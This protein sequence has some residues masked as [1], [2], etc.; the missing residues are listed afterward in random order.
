MTTI[1]GTSGNDILDGT[2]GDDILFGFEGDDVLNGFAGS[3]LLVTGD[4]LDVVFGGDGDDRINGFLTGPANWSVYAAT[5]PVLAYGEAGDDFIG[6]STGD[7]VLIGGPGND[8]LVGRDGSD[9]LE[10]GEGDDELIGSSGDD[11]LVGQAGYDRLDGGAGNDTYVLQG[12]QFLIIDFEG[13]NTIIVERDFVK[14]PYS[15][16]PTP[17]YAPGIKALPYWLDS[18]LDENASSYRGLLGGSS[19]FYFGFPVRLPRYYSNSEYRDGWQPLNN[20][21]QQFVRTTLSSLQ[22]IINLT[23]E[24]TN[25]I[26]NPNVLAFANNKQSGSAAYAI[27]PSRNS[28]GSDVF[29]SVNTPGN[30]APSAGEYAALTVIHEIGHA[31]GLKHPF[32]E[33]PQLTANEDR[34]EW[35]VM[36]YNDNP[37]QHYAR[38][39]PLDIAALHYLYGPSPMLNAGNTSHV[40]AETDHNFIFDGAGSD[41][42]DA[43]AVSQGVTI[44]LAPG[45]W[46]FV[47]SSR[48]SLITGPGQVTVNF[49]TVIENL[50]GSMH[51]DTLVGNEMDN[52]LSGGAGNDTILGAA[53]NDDLDGGDGIDV[54]VFQGQLYQTSADNNFNYTV[55]NED[56]IVTVTGPLADGTDRL[57][58]IERL[59][60]D[61][62]S[63]A[64]DL[65]GGAGMTVK[66][67]GAV[68]GVEG[69][70]DRALRGAGIDLFDNAG[71][72]FEQVMKLA[73][74]VVLGTEPSNEAVVN[75]LW[76]SLVGGTPPLDILAELAGALDNG[77]YSQAGLAV[78]AA[79]HP[80]NLENIGLVG[81]AR[82]GLEY[83]EVL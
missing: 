61:D 34:T 79:E 43:S 9:L 62:Y 45:H 21:Q 82:T 16:D 63:L 15:V 83:L 7:D 69:A 23:F 36:S 6:G 53:G 32:E 40:I 78:A 65:E 68:L 60:F 25:N 57:K 8:F 54:A 33:A 38:F 30:L 51:D 37:A 52:V 72:D 74:E 73:L 39:Q 29:F 58:N 41:T 66:L 59:R 14:V 67:L 50:K 35:T 81:L 55:I 47:G 44:Y 46:G 18:L 64:F 3:D 17:T 76:G 49:G 77:L 26:D 24:E 1:N 75:R 28:M 70:W 80:W 22:S 12:D 19:T 31:L 2:S 10:G 56:G 5:G 71:L 4:G 48:G 27:Y 13:S 42:I 11:L 20:E